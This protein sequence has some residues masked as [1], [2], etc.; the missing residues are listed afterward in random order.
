MATLFGTLAFLGALACWYGAWRSNESAPTASPGVTHGS[1]RD[2]RIGAVGKVLVPPALVG[3]VVSIGGLSAPGGGWLVVGLALALI[4]DVALLASSTRYFVAGLLAFGVAQVAFLTAF[5]AAARAYGLTWW[6]AL[7]GAVFAGLFAATAGRRI[8]R[9]ATS[10]HGS[11]LGYGV[12]GYMALLLAVAA[13]AGATGRWWALG[14][15]LLFVVSDTVLALNR[16]VGPRA[17]SDLVVL[18]TYHLALAGFVAG[19]VA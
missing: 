12:L 15:A 18:V 6:M 11:A 3:L 17:R 13:A 5:V 8:H 9:A 2:A 14:G 1:S 16:F 19:L 4:G 10:S 7:I